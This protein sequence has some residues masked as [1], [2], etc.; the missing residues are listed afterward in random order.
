VPIQRCPRCLAVDI[1]ADAHP[2]RLLR[3]TDI[4]DVFVC[5]DCYRAAELEFRIACETSGLPYVPLSIRDGLRRL[6]FFYRDRLAAWSDPA[7]LLEPADREIA[8][9]PI[10]AALDEVERRLRLIPVREA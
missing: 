10:R 2:T 5:R 4:V 6:A 8:Q 3:G 7:L 9:R 1:S